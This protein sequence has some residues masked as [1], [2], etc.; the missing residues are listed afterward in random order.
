MK[1][2][3]VRHFRMKTIQKSVFGIP[4]KKLKN[5]CGVLFLFLG[6]LSFFVCLLQAFGQDIWFDE[7][8]SVNFIQ[9]SYKEIAALTGKDVHPPLY[10]W[11]LKLFHDIGKVLVP[12]AS[13]IVLCKLASML[14]F[15]GIFVYT[16]TAIRKNFG[17]HVAG[18]FWFLIMT[19]PQISNYTVE[20]RMY[21]LALFFITAAFV[22]SYELVCAFPAQGVSEAE[23]TAEPGAAAGT[24]ETAEP[25]ATAGTEETAES[26]VAAGTEEAA[27][28]G[29]AGSEV[30]SGAVLASGS[31]TGENGLIKWWKRNKHWLLFWVYG[32]LTAY[33]QYYA[34]V[35]VIAI[36]IALFV[37]FVVMAHKGKTEKT[38]CKKTHI[39]KEQL[40]EQEA[41]LT[42]APVKGWK[43]E[44][45]TEQETGRIAGKCIGKVLLCAGL[46]VL[47]YLP[48]LPFFFSQVRTVS[49]SY[50][51]QP[52]TWKSI[53]GCM[54]YIFLPVSYAVKK[55]YVLACVMILVFG[56]AFLYSFLM[57]RKDARGRFFLLT[58]LWIAVFTTLIGF[59]CSILNRPIFVYRYLIPCLGAMWLVAAVVLWDF[60]EKNWGILVFVPFLLSGYSNMQ[61]FYGEENKKI[62][63]MK[64]TQSFLADF[65]KDAVVLCNF[66]HVQAVTA[67]YLKDSNEI[68]LYG[69]NP[70]DLIAE[71]LPQCRG[72]E[73]T[74]ELLQLV[75]ERDVYFFGSFNSREELLKEWETEGI[76][77]TEEGTYLLE[78]YY[79]NVYHLVTNQSHV[80]P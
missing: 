51:I 4:G 30:I 50:W 32:I 54:K 36:Y 52:L 69:S 43:A 55:N 11:Y 22:H 70:E 31:V 13:S 21:S 6:I 10:Y 63:E 38:S 58:G 75:K 76:A 16:L 3:K 5:G 19:M 66:N 44:H 41:I 45:T 72:L 57:K 37:F 17:L 64:A 67:C 42:K 26:G 56:A 71:L 78:R 29:A 40:K 34:C 12:A 48:W 46:S 68:W 18:L 65:P 53:F 27:E 35:A 25:E 7:V 1:S 79:F 39:Y 61:G 15:V 62:V 73:D 74:T 2:V 60:I 77:Y 49:S 59:V 33:T 47:A 80:D 9:H 14:P 24:E 23:R 20:I 8:F 28:P